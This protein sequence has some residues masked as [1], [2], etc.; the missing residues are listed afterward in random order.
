LLKEGHPERVFLT[1]SGFLQ[2]PLVKYER[3]FSKSFSLGEACPPA[4]AGI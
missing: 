3:E 4:K 1:L 2:P